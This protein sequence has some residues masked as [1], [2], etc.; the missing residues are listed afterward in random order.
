M[1]EGQA[2]KVLGFAGSLRK[3]SYNRAALRVAQALAPP[4][5]VIEDFDLSS[6]PLY[7]EDVRLLGFP[8]VVAEFRSRIAAADALLIVTPEYNYSIPGVLKN[9]IDWASRPPDQP[10]AGKPIGIMGA[11]PSMLGTARAQYHLRQC[12]I[13]L[14]AH[15]LNRPEVMIAA[16]QTKFGEDGTLHD[17][18]TR[19][20]IRDL[21][22]GLAGWTERLRRSKLPAGG[23]AA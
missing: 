20:F 8:P 4:G 23:N 5:M 12:F 13:Y 14:D 6:F 1:A 9:A 15:P 19:N 17:E 10:F 7:N 11:S 21:L 18:T 3:G 22:V 2:L 16:A